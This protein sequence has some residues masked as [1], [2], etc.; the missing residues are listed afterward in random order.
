M[1]IKTLIKSAL[2]LEGFDGLFLD[3]ECGCLAD[4]L[5]PC[6]NPSP[7]CEA[8]HKMACDCGEHDWHVGRKK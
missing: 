2:I 3:G 4:D 8:G 5:M 6:G 1:N 7:E